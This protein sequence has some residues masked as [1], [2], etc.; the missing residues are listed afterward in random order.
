MEFM[1]SKLSFSVDP[2]LLEMTV[3]ELLS[4]M[5]AA[6]NRIAY[7]ESQI[8]HTAQYPPNR[9]GQ[10]M[11]HQQQNEMWYP[12]PFQTPSHETELRYPGS[13]QTPSREA[14]LRPQTFYSLLGGPEPP[15]TF[16]AL[17]NHDDY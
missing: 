2:V 9:F 17:G 14:E 16:A 5:T 10:A 15:A 7:L 12:G 1:L 6:E 4:C 8:Q 13:F 11:T 3:Q